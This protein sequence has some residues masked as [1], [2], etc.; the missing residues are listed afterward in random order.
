[1]MLSVLSNNNVNS[2]NEKYVNYGSYNMLIIVVITVL[3][4]MVITIFINNDN[5]FS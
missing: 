3:M 5:S 1:M 4:M 2:N